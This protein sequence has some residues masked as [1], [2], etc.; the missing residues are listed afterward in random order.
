MTGP[1]LRRLLPHALALL[2]LLVGVALQFDRPFA[3]PLPAPPDTGE[4]FPASFVARVRAYRDPRYPLAL[5][6]LLVSLAVPAWWALSSRGRRLTARIAERCG[7]HRPLR[8]AAF[9]AVAILVSIDLVTLPGAFWSGYVQEG[10]FGFRTQGP[11]GWSRDWLV[12]HAPVWLGAALLACLASVVVRRFRH[13]W[14]AVL[15]LSIG[16]LGAVLTTLAPILLEP[17]WLDTAPLGPGPVRDAVEE[18]LERADAPPARI[19]VADASR[20]S[21][22]AN[23]YV[24]GLGATRRV[25]LFDTLLAQATPQEVALV[26]AHELAHDRH[27][28]ITR[29]VGLSVAGGVV[30][31]YGVAAALRLASASGRITGPADPRAVPAAV[32]VA[33]LLVTAGLPVQRAISRRAEAAADWGALELT[34]APEDFARVQYT[35]AAS[36]LADPDPPAW[37]RWLWFTHP[38]PRERIGMAMA[39]AERAGTPLDVGPLRAAAGGEPR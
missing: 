19:L 24:S 17:L 30:A 12:A 34:R 39:W 18:V 37:A 3:P 25:V 21:T 36:H 7:P 10:R 38:G 22:K 15:A 23:A 2:A 1:R 26:V 20:R 14:P 27:G 5:A 31:V 32:L 16:V 9:L 13:A 11:A 8:A 6:L 33:L 35:L 28:D 29:G 4:L